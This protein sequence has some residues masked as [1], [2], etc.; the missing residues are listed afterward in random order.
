MSLPPCAVSAGR[1]WGLVPKHIT[2][3]AVK[4]VI[5]ARLWISSTSAK[6]WPSVSSVP[7]DTLLSPQGGGPG[8]AALTWACTSRAGKLYAGPSKEQGALNPRR[9]PWGLQ[10]SRGTWKNQ[11]L[12]WDPQW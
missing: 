4:F 9:G 7:G 8:P 1:G 5:R 11:K 12:T 6:P 3:P 2:P 10:L